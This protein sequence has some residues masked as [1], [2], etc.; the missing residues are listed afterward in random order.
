MRQCRGICQA[1]ARPPV[2][3]ALGRGIQPLTLFGEPLMAHDTKI[4]VF[5]SSIL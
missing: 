3:S 2:D 5:K 1:R 4:T